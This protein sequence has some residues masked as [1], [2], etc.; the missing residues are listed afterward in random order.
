MLN[1][2]QTKLIEKKNLA[3]EVFFF[4]FELINPKE[5]DFIPGEYMILKVDGKPRLYSIASPVTEKN[6]LEFVIELVLGGLASQYLK[7]LSLGDEVFFQGP[8]GMF[9]FKDEDKQNIFLATGTGIAP[10]RSM[11]YSKIDQIKNNFY[12]FWGLRSFED[13]YFLDEF[14]ALKQKSNGRFNFVYCLSRE[15]D[16]SK[17]K[18]EDKKHFFLGRVQNAFD[19]YFK[20][21]LSFEKTN[22][23]LCGRREVVEDLRSFLEEK[24]IKKENILFERF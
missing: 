16:L 19:L 10:I 20:N 24:N 23:Y 11:I 17:I 4:K 22:F 5:I 6:F 1:L 8:A 18:K 3:K 14:K 15:K 9:H 2:Y 7:K 21:S 12:L 13:V